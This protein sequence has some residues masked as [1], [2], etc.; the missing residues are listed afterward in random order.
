MPKKTPLWFRPRGYLHFDSPISYK[1]AQSIV[2]NINRVA[3]HSFYPLI[4]YNIDSYKVF[5]DQ[6]GEIEKKEKNRPIAYAAHIDSHIYAF[7]AYKLNLAY[8]LQVKNLGLD[9]NILAF[10]SLGNSNIEF[11]NNAFEDIKSRKVCTALALDVK[12][13]FDNLDHLQLKNAWAKILDENQLPEDHYNIFKSLTR[14]SKV[15][16]KAL[17]EKLEIPTSNPKNG[18]NRACDINTFRTCVRGTGLIEVNRKGF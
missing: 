7:Y 9:E 15:D 13:F 10:R 17:Y 6:Q 8:E 5:K 2:T 3:T 18:R 16:R 11:A 4:H 14:F 1:K 12:G